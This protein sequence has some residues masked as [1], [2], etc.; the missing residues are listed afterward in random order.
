VITQVA[1][2]FIPTGKVGIKHWILALQILMN[3]FDQVCIP[4]RAGHESIE[5]LDSNILLLLWHY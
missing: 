5:H 3:L 1:M 4:M 2:P